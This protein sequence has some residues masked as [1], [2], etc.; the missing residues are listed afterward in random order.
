MAM[1]VKALFPNNLKEIDK[2]LKTIKRTHKLSGF[3][4]NN[5]CDLIKYNEP[6][7]IHHFKMNTMKSKVI[8]EISIIGNRKNVYVAK[9]A[10]IYNLVCINVSDG[11]VYID[12]GAVIRPF[13]TIIGPS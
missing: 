3:I 12:K 4:L 13:T 9:D 1:A 5:I 6:M 11:P 7:M 2:V 10:I 8:K